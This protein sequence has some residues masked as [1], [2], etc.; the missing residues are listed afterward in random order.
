MKA[1]LRLCVFALLALLGPIVA[2]AGVIYRWQDLNLD[3]D[4]GALTGHI[5]FSYDAWSAGG[6]VDDIGGS[7]APGNFQ[8]PLIGVERFIWDNPSQ[9][10]FRRGLDLSLELCSKTDWCPGQFPDDLEIFADW[11]GGFLSSS[12]VDVTFGALLTG[13]LFFGNFEMGVGM[14]SDGA[15]WTI[16][17]MGTDWDGNCHSDCRGGTGLWV[18]D[19]STLPP[20][21]VPE[22]SMPV[23]IAFAGLA[24]FVSRKVKCSHCR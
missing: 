22:P 20:I 17:Q 3:P 8:D 6:T 14:H 19:L 13:R 4:V 21:R 11:S 12:R 23:L 24:L 1:N 10:G 9:V 15:L 2:S 5:E 18:L 16:D 7:S